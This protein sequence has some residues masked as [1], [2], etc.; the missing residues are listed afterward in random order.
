MFLKYA[1]FSVLFCPLF[2]KVNNDTNSS[3]L[4]E[5]QLAKRDAEE[6]ERLEKQR[7]L[8]EEE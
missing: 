5:L 8:Q 3:G 2:G 7:L 6:K 4:S 1:L